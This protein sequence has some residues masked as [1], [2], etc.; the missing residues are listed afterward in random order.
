MN[1]DRIVINFF[2]CFISTPVKTYF[3]K[4]LKDIVKSKILFLFYLCLAVIKKKKKGI[5]KRPNSKVNSNGEVN[6]NRQN[7]MF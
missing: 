1:L 3:I 4:Q 2:T 5:T 6:N 7:L